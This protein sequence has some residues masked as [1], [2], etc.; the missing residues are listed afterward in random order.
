MNVENLSSEELFT[1]AKKKLAEEETIK[2]KVILNSNSSVNL[3]MIS[4]A[5]VYLTERLE[6]RELDTQWAYELIMKSVFG[7]DIFTYIDNL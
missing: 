5:E 7:N 4:L 1:L 2:P 6:G 3:A